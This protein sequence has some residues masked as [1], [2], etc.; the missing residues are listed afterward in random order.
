MGR[1]VRLRTIEGVVLAE[2]LEIAETFLERTRGLLG[3]NSLDEGGGLYLCPCSSIHMFFMRFAIDVLF[4]ARDL[5]VCRVVHRLRPW[6]LAGC[7]GAYGTIELPEG[8]LSRVS[9]QRGDRL[10]IED[11]LACEVSDASR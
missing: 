10:V 7:V 8:C 3:R 4:V 9:V 11:P 6:R 1:L 2:S 5:R